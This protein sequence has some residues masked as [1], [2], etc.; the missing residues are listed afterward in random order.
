VFVNV[1]FDLLGKFAI[2]RIAQFLRKPHDG[3]RIN[4]Q[5]LR[6]LGRREERR[7]ESVVQD[8]IGQPAESRGELR[9]AVSDAVFKH[10]NPLL[11]FAYAL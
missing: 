1:L 5:P 7:L 11:M 3:R 6:E 9:V 2:A 10:L 4:F 8:E